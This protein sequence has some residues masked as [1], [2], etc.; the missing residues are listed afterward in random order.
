MPGL[1]KPAHPFPLLIQGRL[2]YNHCR[3]TT[4]LSLSFTLR[5]AVFAATALCVA[6]VAVMMMDVVAM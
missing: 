1:L 2:Q 4:T 3:D 6:S 5:L